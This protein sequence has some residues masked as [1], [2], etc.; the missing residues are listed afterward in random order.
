MEVLVV[1]GFGDEYLQGG[2]ARA[3]GA[4]LEDVVDRTPVDL[5]QRTCGRQPHVG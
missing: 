2:F 1:F 3:D 4:V 5:R